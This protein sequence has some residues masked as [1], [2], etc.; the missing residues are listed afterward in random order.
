VRFDYWA[1]RV[2]KPDDYFCLI[3]IFVCLVHSVFYGRRRCA[4]L[5]H[6]A[7]ANEQHF[8]DRRRVRLG[9]REGFATRR[10]TASFPPH[11]ARF[12]RFEPL[13]G[14]QHRS[15]RVRRFTVSSAPLTSISIH[16]FSCSPSRTCSKGC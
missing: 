11:A 2:K 15:N 4:D 1:R 8:R 7:D 6:V 13:P 12:P 9:R 5:V 3:L 16:V 14:R 10:R